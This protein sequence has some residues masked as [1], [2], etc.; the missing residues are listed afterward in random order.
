MPKILQLVF[1]LFILKNII[2][3]VINKVI[4]NRLKANK[5]IMFKICIISVAQEKLYAQRF[6]G[7]RLKF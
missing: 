3:G 6:H 2:A 4:T 7:K 5:P 1:F